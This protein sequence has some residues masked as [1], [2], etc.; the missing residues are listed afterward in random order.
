MAIAVTCPSCLKR[1]SVSD[2]FAGR[3]GPCPNCQKPIKIPDKAEEVVIHAPEDS[4]PKDSSGKS[5]LSPVRRKE[6]QLSMPVILGVSLSAFAIVAISFGLGLSGQQPPF[7][8]LAVGALLL[9]PPLVFV[10]YWFLRDDELEGF[11]GQQLL[12]R[13]AICAIAFAVLWAVY[14]FVP[15]YVSGYASMGEMSGLDMVIYL[16]LM[17]VIGAAISVA[18]LE[19]EVLQGAMHYGFYLGI[20]FVL[21]WLAG[22]HL[23]VPLGG[24]TPSGPDATPP[25]ATAP[26]QPQTPASDPPP[27]DR[28]IPSVLQ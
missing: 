28:K 11:K 27:D 25:P 16:T 12:L 7:P 2:Q 10:G 23:S 18:V 15:G 21:A 13:C 6:V 9:A 22:T 8:L 1:F 14:G 26:D 24:D 5:I 17:L 4:G 19:L 3:T 20:T